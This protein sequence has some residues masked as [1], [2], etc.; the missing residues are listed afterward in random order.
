M[1]KISVVINT[2]NEEKNIALAIKSV[3]EFADEVVVVDMHS[4]D[5]TCEVAE[6]LGAKVFTFERKSY[7]EPARNFAISKA[8]GDW[9]FILDADERATPQLLAKLKKIVKEN[10]Y[11]FVN[12]PR[13]NLIFGKWIRHSLW[14]PDYNIRFFRKGSVTWKDE[15]HSQPETK[16]KGT[17]LLPKE[18]YAIVHRNYSSV[19]S[20]I[21]RMNRYTDIQAQEKIKEGYVFDW[22]DLVRRPTAEFVRR[23]F[24]ASGY[25]DGLHGLAL[26]LLQSCSELVLYLKLWQ[27]NKFNEADFDLDEL[28]QEL[29]K[30]ERELNYWKADMLLKLNKN[31][32]INSLFLRLKR[33]LRI[34]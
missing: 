15:I 7:V 24:S 20:Y 12:I 18:K 2:L 30:S 25:K 22:K 5:K 29:V 4:E 33:K 32:K 14:W 6:S 23:F 26:A 13:K 28:N 34:S 31:K 17:N 27:A 3:R 8:S 10:Q 1:K 21:L 11:D 19:S 16:G 9:I